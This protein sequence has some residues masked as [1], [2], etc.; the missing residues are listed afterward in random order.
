M[1]VRAERG[2]LVGDVE[3]ALVGAGLAPQ[4]RLE[5]RHDIV[6]RDRAQA[7]A[8]QPR[9]IDAHHASQLGV[10]GGDAQVAIEDEHSDGRLFE[11]RLVALLGLAQRLERQVA[12]VDVDARADVLDQA[13][14][15]VYHRRALYAE[16][17]VGAVAAT[18]AQ[19]H[20]EHPDAPDSRGPGRGHHVAVVGVDGGPLHAFHL[21]GGRAGELQEAL[22]G[23]NERAVGLP[24]PY[25]RR[26]RVSQRPVAVVAALQ[27]RDGALSRGDIDEDAMC[28]AGLPRHVEAHATVEGHGDRRAVGADHL[29]LR[30]Q[31][32]ARREPLQS[33]PQA[34]RVGRDQKLGERTADHVVAAVLKGL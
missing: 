17:F 14:L 33:R 27:G 24:R 1:L 19:L 21:V 10:A 11:Q 8:D 31:P 2:V 22:V 20:L 26:R 30:L 9:R 29:E 3:G 16:P 6:R 32:S 13:A 23:L 12:F 7:T 28:L 5:G 18:H 15:F 34:R 4:R 25:P